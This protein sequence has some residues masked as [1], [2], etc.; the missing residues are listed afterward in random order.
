MNIVVVVAAQLLSHD[1]L[2]VTLWTAAHQ[3]PLS[4]T[5]SQSLLK[6]MSKVGN[7]IQ[8]SH[9]LSPPSPS[10]LSLAQQQGLFQ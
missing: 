4:F 8:P 2:F 10:A 1:R 3:P 9:P 5:T 7:V 6:F